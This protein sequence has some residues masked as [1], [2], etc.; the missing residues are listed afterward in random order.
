MAN[1]WTP[2]R[3]A[4]QA[5]LIRGW[6]PWESSTGP[7][8]AQGKARSRMNRYRGGTKQ[9]VREFARLMRELLGG[10]ARLLE[11]VEEAAN[12]SDGPEAGQLDAI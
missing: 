7:R 12:A 9:K 4:K 11:A 10:N 6:R 8:T 1:G 5:E 2:E 3:R